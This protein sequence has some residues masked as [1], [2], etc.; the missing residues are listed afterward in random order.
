MPCHPDNP[1][2]AA[3]PLQRLRAAFEWCERARAAGSIKAYGLATWTCFRQGRPG[4]T[5]PRTLCA[6][7]CALCAAHQARLHR[8][9]RF[10]LA[11][12][13]LALVACWVRPRCHRG[14]GPLLGLPS[15]SSSTMIRRILLQGASK[16]PPAPEPSV[17]CRAGGGSGRHRP[18]VQVGPGVR[19][20]SWC[21]HGT[22]ASTIRCPDTCWLGDS[23]HAAL[24]RIKC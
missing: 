16:R 7:R 22:P 9:A 2:A 14:K 24:L 4:L 8:Q 15:R 10:V 23:A 11:A 6:A 1:A 19:W 20:V 5:P 17:H 18:W 13:C 12:P 21:G 3:P